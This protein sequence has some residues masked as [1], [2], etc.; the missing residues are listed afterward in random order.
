ME[1]EDVRLRKKRIVRGKRCL[2]QPPEN[3]EDRNRIRLSMDC[4]E[5]KNKNMSL[6][7]IKKNDESIIRKR[8]FDERSIDSLKMAKMLRECP[9]LRIPNH[10][11]FYVRVNPPNGSKTLNQIKMQPIFFIPS[12]EQCTKQRKYNENENPN[13]NDHTINCTITKDNTDKQLWT[14]LDFQDVL[15]T[16][17]RVFPTVK[18]AVNDNGRDWTKVNPFGKLHEYE[19]QCREGIVVINL[20]EKFGVSSECLGKDFEMCVQNYVSDHGYC[21]YVFH[22]HMMLYQPVDTGVYSMMKNKDTR[23]FLS[24]IYFEFNQFNKIIFKNSLFVF[25]ATCILQY[26]MMKIVC[27]FSFLS[28][29]NC[30]SYLLQFYFYLYFF[31][32]LCFL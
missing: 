28:L 27:F 32:F 31:I 24:L 7:E 14:K 15:D 23:N 3:M 4:E 29:I 12:K 30:F 5:M 6:K 25:F 11:L 19:L 8:K 26:E 17:V 1:T 13:A 22:H 2:H 21:G 18:A 9:V 16:W 20:N 10:S